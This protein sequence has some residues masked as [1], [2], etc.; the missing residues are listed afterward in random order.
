V[1]VQA[2]QE[3]NMTPEANLEASR[4]AIEEAFGEGRLEVL[5]E[6]CAED[7]VGHDPIAGD[8]DLDAVKATIRS[9]RDAFPDLSFT[10]EDAFASGDR[11][12]IRWRGEGTFENEFLGQEPTG[13]K[14]EPTHGI[15]IDR[16]D[17]DGKIAETWN[18]WDTLGLMRAIGLIPEGEAATA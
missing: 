15:T 6:I 8:Q 18:Q 10:I 5:D 1:D 3:V 2:I 12:A 9:Y 14:G 4:R 11:A 16:F 7:F 17:E 13:E